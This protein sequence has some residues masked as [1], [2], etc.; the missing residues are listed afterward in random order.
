MTLQPFLPH[1]ERNRV[2]GPKC[3]RLIRFETIAVDAVCQVLRGA[4]RC[5][6]SESGI[7]LLRP[8]ITPPAPIARRKGVRLTKEN[9]DTDFLDEG[10]GTRGGKARSTRALPSPS[11][12]KVNMSSRLAIQW[13]S[14]MELL[15][16]R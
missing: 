12:V 11:G 3:D 16:I 6:S 9:R 10:N 7:L 15:T 2:A 13:L 8:F 1:R 14:G 4:D 5:S